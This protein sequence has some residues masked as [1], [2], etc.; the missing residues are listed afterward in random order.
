MK[1]G[2]GE[3]GGVALQTDVYPHR[4]FVDRFL[5]MPIPDRIHWH[6]R[7]Q[8]RRAF[9]DPRQTLWRWCH[10]TRPHRMEQQNRKAK[11]KRTEARGKRQQERG[12]EEASCTGNIAGNQ[13][14]RGLAPVLTPAYPIGYW[15]RQQNLMYKT[16][17]YTSL[18]LYNA[19]LIASFAMH[20]NRVATTSI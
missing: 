17:S 3:I 11:A 10:T 6:Q 4:S 1:A 15:T 13:V 20:H 8:H 5:H 2:S 9:T 18:P 19:D 12:K 7:R 16:R 14:N